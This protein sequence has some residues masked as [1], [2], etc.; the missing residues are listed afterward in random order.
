MWVLEGYILDQELMRRENTEAISLSEPPLK[1]VQR[2]V[3][4]AK[5]LNRRFGKGT[6]V[7]GTVM[8]VPFRSNFHPWLHLQL[9]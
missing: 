3:E 1:A 6:G 8:S 2:T 7:V 4:F 9:F 5:A